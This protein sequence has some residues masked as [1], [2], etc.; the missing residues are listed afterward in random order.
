M[1]EEAAGSGSDRPVINGCKDD[2]DSSNQSR[3]KKNP[4]KFHLDV[5]EFECGIFT[6][7]D[8]WS[9]HVGWYLPGVSFVNK[10]A[11]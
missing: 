1:A 11:L 2:F 9:E 5:A 4:K 6:G 8:K 10:C 7:A 3:P